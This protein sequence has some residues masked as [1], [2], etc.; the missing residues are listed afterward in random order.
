MA[1]LLSQRKAAG[2]AANARFK[3]ASRLGGGEDV[4]AYVFAAGLLL[5]PTAIVYAIVPGAATKPIAIFVAGFILGMLAFAWDT[6]PEYIERWRRGAE[7]ERK[8]R[9]PWSPSSRV[10]GARF[11]TCRANTATAT[12]CSSD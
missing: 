11:T 2:R 10:D 5:A 8:P 9:G 4:K 3:Q 1:S 12:T 6:P 7:G